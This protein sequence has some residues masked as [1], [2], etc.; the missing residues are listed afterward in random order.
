MNKRIDCSLLVS[1]ALSLLLVASP[2]MAKFYPDDS[3]PSGRTT[4]TGPRDYNP[5]PDQPVPIGSTTSTGTRGGGK[6][7]S[8][9]GP[10]L[11][12]LA[13]QKQ[14][15]L[16]ASTHPTF[17]WFVPDAK[18]L[19]MEFSLYKYG[20]NKKIKPVQPLLKLTSSP[21]IMQLS[22][23][24]DG[25]GLTVGQRYL[26]QVAIFCNPNHPSTALVARAEIQAVDVSPTLAKT[27]STTQAPLERANLYAKS[28]L[29][30]D[31]LREAL[32][33]NEAPRLRGFAADLLKELADLEEP[34]QSA[35]LRQIASKV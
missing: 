29:W 33:N 35:N 25:P 20:P 34:K 8:S 22:L 4:S 31:A 5:P 18:P 7:E 24:E 28:S 6:C 14:V 16:T 17:A 1:C 9:K 30:Y 10:A 23:P 26:W 3:K 2:V 11:T 21:G 12:V 15:G 32:G 13:P 27:L 19:P